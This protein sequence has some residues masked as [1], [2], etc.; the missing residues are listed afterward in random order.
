MANGATTD[1]GDGGYNTGTSESWNSRRVGFVNL[2]FD[3]TTGLPIGHS[4]PESLS[5]YATPTGSVRGV[6]V[7]ES[8]NGGDTIAFAQLD[9]GNNV[10][11]YRPLSTT[12]NPTSFALDDNPA[13]STATNDGKSDNIFVD[14]DSG[15][16]IIVESGFGDATP[17]EPGVLRLHINSYDNGSGQIDVGTW[18]P[19]VLLNPMKTTGA[20][21][22]N[23]VRGYWS[24]YDSATDKVFFVNPGA[25]SPETP[26]FGNDLWVLDLATGTT[27]SYLDVDDSISLFTGDAFGDKVAAFTLAA[28]ADADFDNDSDVDGNDFLIWQR[29]L[30]IG[31]SNTTGDANGN[32]VVDGADLAIWKSQFVQATASGA[33]AAVPE[34]AA[35]GLLAV[36]LAAV[37]ARRRRG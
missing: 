19:K 25:G 24:A 15:D 13:A 3:G 26:Q 1:F 5:Y 4:E 18:D 36:G 33:A 14:K 11:G 2:D 6:W 29:G 7:A 27:T 21:A 34:P 31:N 17:T 23:L 22:T 32:G 9:T 16:L 37:A 30:G 8:D 10:V 20:S 28:A 12:G 35:A